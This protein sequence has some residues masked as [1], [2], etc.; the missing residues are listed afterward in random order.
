MTG[1]TAS[2]NV[3]GQQQ[4]TQAMFGFPYTFIGLENPLG[5]FAQVCKQEGY[6]AL[7][8]YICKSFKHILSEA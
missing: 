3:Q 2:K 1:L 6:I 8:C 5:Q 7:Q 4:A